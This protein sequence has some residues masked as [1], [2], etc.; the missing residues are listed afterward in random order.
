MGLYLYCLGHPSHPPP[1][2]IQGLDG[3]A[4]RAEPV[5]GFSA[6]I[7]DMDRAPGASLERVRTHNDVVSAATETAT[8]LPLRFGQWFASHQELSRSL[9]ERRH[10]LAEDLERVQNA[11]E[12]GVRV[13]DPHHQPAVPA[14]TTGTAYL[15]GL[16]RQARSD[17]A[18]RS[19]GQDVAAELGAWLGPLV[20]DQRVRL[21]GGGTLAATAHLVDRHDIGSYNARVRSF[22]PRR[23]ELRFL[24]TGPWPPYGFVE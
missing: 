7:S 14:R 10:R 1:A 9:E 5:A 16:A 18:D 19:R 12:F 22:P 21:V 17:E 24:L 8:P 2:S 23:P 15:E 4:V 11:L 3:A 6:W 13:L 20:R